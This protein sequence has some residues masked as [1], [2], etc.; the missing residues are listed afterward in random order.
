MVVLEQGVHL[1]HL[2][3]GQRLGHEDAVVAQV[4]LGAG[5]ARG[6]GRLGALEG[7][8]LEVVAVVDAETLAEVAEHQRAVFFHLRGSLWVCL[9][10]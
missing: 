3:R 1:L 5:L 2:L 10:T 4:E 8:R 7:E 6:V 9:V